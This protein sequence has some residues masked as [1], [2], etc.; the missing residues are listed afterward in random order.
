MLLPNV[1][2]IPVYFLSSVCGGFF[3]HFWA[4]LGSSQLYHYVYG[5]AAVGGLLLDIVHSLFFSLCPHFPETCLP[6]AG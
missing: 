6:P 4:A 1:K 3:S 2:S 5:T